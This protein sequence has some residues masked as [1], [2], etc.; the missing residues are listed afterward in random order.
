MFDNEYCKVEYLEENRTVLLTWKKFSSFENYRKPTWY[1]YEL[2]AEHKNTN[3]I[4]DARNGFE[5]EK[6]DVEWGFKVLLPSMAKTD[7]KHVIFV[8]NQITEIEGEMDMWGDEFRKYFTVTKVTSVEDGL[9]K[10]AEL[11]DY[12][13]MN[14]TYTIK[15]GLREEFYQKLVKDNIAKESKAEHGN[16]AYDFYASLED[17]NQ[18]LLVEAWTNADSQRKH[19]VSDTY[20]R[21]SKLKVEYVEKVIINKYTKQI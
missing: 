6:E 8:M 14:V 5:D 2:L 15:E 11:E 7:C 1:A 17:Q 19:L 13:W 16:A 18:L 9:K 20:S 4:I 21:L 12:I 10:L 3:F